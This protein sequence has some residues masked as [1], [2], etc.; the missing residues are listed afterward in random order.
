MEGGYRLHDMML[1]RLLELAGPETTVVICSD[2]GFHPDHLRPMK[3]P[4]EPAGPAAEHRHH[5]IV[6]M[7]GPGIGEDEL[8]YGASLL[9]ITPTILALYGLPV[10]EDMDGKA[11]VQHVKE[12]SPLQTI[13]SWEAVAGES[14]GYTDK[15]QSDPWAEK[16]AMDQLVALGYIEAPDEDADKAIASC[17]RESK[18]Y[19]ARNY[20]HMNQ[21]D[22]AVDLLEELFAEQPDQTRFGLRLAHV[23]LKLNKISEGRRVTDITLAAW[24]QRT[25][26]QHQQL[27]DK[28]RDKQGENIPEPLTLEKLRQRHRPSLDLLRERCLLPKSG[29]KRRWFFSY[30]PG[31]WSRL[32]DLHQ[33]LG[34]LYFKNAALPGRRRGFVPGPG[35]RP[36]Q[37]RRLPWPGQGL[38]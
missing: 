36:G 12:S 27:V 4:K 21:Y 22:K 13:P 24:E 15:E 10:G 32:P 8:I 35:Y 30:G 28:A 34:N 5:G 17:Q 23:Y 1:A 31:G 11:L 3:L 38:S 29:M 7:N 25:L 18:Y 19:L 33:Q 37:C 20:I 9:D 2:H 14:G 16:A 26:K 6:V